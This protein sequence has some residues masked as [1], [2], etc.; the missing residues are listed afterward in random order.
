MCVYVYHVQLEMERAL[1]EGEHKTEMEQLQEEQEKINQLKQHQHNMLE[2][3]TRQR[4]K[5]GL[6]A[7]TSCCNPT[8]TLSTTFRHLPPNSDRCGYAAEVALFI[9]VQLSTDAVSAL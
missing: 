2:R 8:H 6:A 3:A 4:E 9:S 7:I 1:L 5:V